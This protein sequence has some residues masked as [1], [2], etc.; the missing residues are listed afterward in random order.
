MA[1]DSCFFLGWHI[2][3]TAIHTDWSP[4]ASVTILAM[5]LAVHNLYPSLRPYTEPFFQ[6]QY[7]QPNT[8]L[9]TQGWDDI[10][11]VICS[12]IGFTAVRAIAIDWVFW[13]MGRRWGLKR[14]ASIRLAEQAWMAIYYGFFWSCGM[15]RFLFT[16]AENKGTYPLIYFP[17]LVS[18]VS[19]QLLARFQ[20]SLVRLAVAR[21]DRFHEVVSSYAV[22]VLDAAAFGDPR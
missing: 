5:L 2:S 9:Y 10:Y 22:V 6:L 18:L 14:K 7:Y 17:L 1:A 11:F 4:G 20:G 13:P 15:V 3:Y 12:A 8:G 16:S 19:F 21:N